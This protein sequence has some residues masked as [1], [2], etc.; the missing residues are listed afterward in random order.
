V[1][2]WRG[3]VPRM[4]QSYEQALE[5]R[6]AL[7]D[8]DGIAEALYNLSFAFSYVARQGQEAPDVDRA[9]ELQEQALELFRQTVN[10][11]GEGRALWA[12]GATALAQ[13]DFPT[14]ERSG[15]AAEPIFRELG[16]RYYLG[17]SLWSMVVG[18]IALGRLDQARAPAREA[19]QLFADA[20]DVSG[21]AGLLDAAAIIA[22]REGDRQRAARLSGAVD[23]LARTSGLDARTFGRTLLDFD[24]DALASAPETRAAWQEGAA[25][26]RP[27]LIAYGLEGL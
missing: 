1:D 16:D 2:Y 11:S 7:G 25:M 8:P 6:Q 5:A 19:L 4:R 20:D 24:A 17:W 9:R 18:R 22:F 26:E 15:T 21:Y 27:A 3:D 10:R 23:E 13:R 12:L 14:L